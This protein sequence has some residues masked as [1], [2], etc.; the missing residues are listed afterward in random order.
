MCRTRFWTW[1]GSGWNAGS[2]ASAS[3][4]STSTSTTAICATIPPLPPDERN[5]STAP[6]V[7]PYNHQEHLFDKNQ[8][9]NLAFLRRFRAVLDPY[10][11]AAVGEVGDA[12]RGLEI[13]GEYTSGGDK[14][15]MCY[16]STCCQ[17]GG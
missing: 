7:N 5:D 1:R 14:V 17:P 12:Q 9:E 4:R 15:Q 8:P 3:T 16:P 11:A 10:G 6:A 13:M 2:T